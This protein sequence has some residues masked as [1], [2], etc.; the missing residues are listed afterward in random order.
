MANI[1]GLLGHFLICFSVRYDVMAHNG[2]HTS[3]LGKKMCCYPQGGDMVKQI[4]LVQQ[5]RSYV[6]HLQWARDAKSIFYLLS[7][8]ASLSCAKRSHTSVL[9]L[10]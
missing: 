4:L 5:C 10:T 8:V 3:T 7:F 6:K 2:L 1:L 9:V